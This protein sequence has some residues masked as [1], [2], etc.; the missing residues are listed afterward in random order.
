[1]VVVVAV[2]VAVA[3]VVVWAPARPDS[4]KDSACA[5]A[6]MLWCPGYDRPICKRV[7]VWEAEEVARG[8]GED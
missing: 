8:V 3:V 2:A 6:E 5:R 4:K 1:M 7:Q